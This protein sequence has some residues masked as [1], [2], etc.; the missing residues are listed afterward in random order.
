[1]YNRTLPFG[2]STTLLIAAWDSNSPNRIL[3]GAPLAALLVLFDLVI[4]NPTHPETTANLALLDVGSGHFSGLEY[5]SQGTLPGSIIS[6]FTQ[7]ARA[8]VREKSDV[9]LSIRSLPALPTPWAVTSEEMPETILADLSSAFNSY[10]D[11][12]HFPHGW[13]V[14]NNDGVVPGTDMLGL[15]GSYFPLW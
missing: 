12:Q 13:N 6:E 8:Y 10:T 5:A 4:D 2:K 14:R 9:E 11:L 1:M 15:F 3:A 7:I